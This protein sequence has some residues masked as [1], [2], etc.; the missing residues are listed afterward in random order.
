MA[1]DTAT[2]KAQAAGLLHAAAL[3]AAESFP[4]DA[5]FATAGVPDR[6][7][8][9]ATRHDFCVGQVPINPAIAAGA[10]ARPRAYPDSVDATL[11]VDTGAI[12][13]VVRAS[14]DAGIDGSFPEAL[15][16][17]YTRAI[18]RGHGN[19]DLP[20]LYEAFTRE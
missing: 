20:A 9:F 1:T 19:H 18:A 11:A 4:L 14:R 6:L 12:G 7:L 8:E 2:V 16:A 15:L 3:C 5:F 17:A 10:M 13:Q